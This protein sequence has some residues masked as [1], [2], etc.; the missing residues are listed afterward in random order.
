MNTFFFNTC[1]FTKVEVFF[2]LLLQKVGLLHRSRQSFVSERLHFGSIESS[3]N[4]QKVFLKALLK[5]KSMLI[6]NITS[7][8][9]ILFG[10]IIKATFF[11][12]NFYCTLIIKRQ[13]LYF[14]DQFLGVSLACS[15]ICG[16]EQTGPAQP[17]TAASVSLPSTSPA[18]A[19][20]VQSPPDCSLG[21]LCP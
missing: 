18:N 7:T 21:V 1:N 3:R 5:V 8:R 13:S 16:L 14:L 11:P 9:H 4:V 19:I 6:N 20:H 10:H 17:Q 12:A 15:L 2:L